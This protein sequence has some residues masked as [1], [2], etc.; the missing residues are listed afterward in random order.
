MSISSSPE[1]ALDRPAGSGAMLAFLPIRVSCESGLRNETS[2]AGVLPLLPLPC[3]PVDA[4]G[5]Q[6]CNKFYMRL[7]QT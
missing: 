5:L 7:F 2:A 3:D 1:D 4:L 6:S